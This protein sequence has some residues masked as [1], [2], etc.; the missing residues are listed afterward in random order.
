MEE[1]KNAGTPDNSGPTGNPNTPPPTPQKGKTARKPEPKE[2]KKSAAGTV[3]MLFLII[4]LIGVV[5]FLLFQDNKKTKVIKAQVER[6]NKDSVL[7]A[8]QV[9]DLEETRLQLQRMEDDAKEMEASYK[10][11]LRLKIAEVDNLIIKLKKA[12]KYKK[13]YDQAISLQAKVNAMD[14]ELSQIKAQ[15]DSAMMQ[16]ASLTDEGV[17]LKDTI[18]RMTEERTELQEKVAIASILRA[19]EFKVIGLN[20]KGKEYD[21]TPLKSKQLDKLKLQFAIGENKVARKNQKEII[22]RLIEPDGTVLFAGIDGGSFTTTEGEEKL[23]TLSQSISFEGSKKSVSFV[24]Q[25]GNEYKSGKHVIEIYA[26][27][28]KIG[29]TSFQVK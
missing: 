20:A 27:G 29:E 25:K 13:Y 9:K 24:Y 26:E 17:V 12:N 5:G 19:E 21:A 11:S 2:K 10:D 15:R 23:Y 14:I 8:Q 28:H 3:I 4:G 6:I 16:V 1:N 7:I 18:S 22:M